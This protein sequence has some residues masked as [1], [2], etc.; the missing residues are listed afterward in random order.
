MRAERAP[1]E[2]LE[3]PLLRTM[4]RLRKLNENL[5]KKTSWKLKSKFSKKNFQKIKKYKIKLNKIKI[6]KSYDRQSRI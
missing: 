2:R 3:S 6:Y 1:R 5:K 4:E